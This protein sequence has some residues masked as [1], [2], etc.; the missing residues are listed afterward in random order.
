MRSS[1]EYTDAEEDSVDERMWGWTVE[2]WTGHVARLCKRPAVTP[3]ELGAVAR[4]W[5]CGGNTSDDVSPDPDTPW[6]RAQLRR[7]LLDVRVRELVD[8]GVHV[9]DT[10]SLWVDATVEIAPGAHL[11]PGV[12]LVG[13]TTVA[14]G[15]TVQLGCH[16]TDTEVGE[17]A[18]VKPH[19]VTDG[20][21][22][23]PGAAVGPCAHLRTGAD[24]GRDVK[25]GNFVEVKKARLDDGAKAS[26]LSYIGD[27]TVGAAANIG[28][29]TI[30]CNYDG[31]GKHRTEIGS[32]A[33]I[34]SNTAL[35]APVRV[36]AGAIVGA[37]SV[38]TR[39]V[40]DDDLAVE[41]SD[42]RNLKGY[43]RKLRA[44]NARR[45]GKTP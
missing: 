44:A 8:G 2:Q 18:V 9:D 14:A 26:H 7:I 17:G 12:R 31:Y 45:A 37:G 42:Q 23:G 6:G 39:D 40:A 24:L 22:I 19:T 13:T 20:A 33:F 41:R 16:L 1:P 36:G 11:G 30:T 3:S 25:V 15:A 28:A 21:R 5:V 35:V 4:A 10:S 43:A 32:G 38:I 29:G 34:G 27:A